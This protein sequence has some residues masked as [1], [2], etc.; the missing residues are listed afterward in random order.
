ML[1]CTSV[2]LAQNPLEIVRRSVER[3][4]A[5][6]ERAKEYTYVVHSRMRERDAGGRVKKEDSEA[7]EVVILYGE[8]F[9]RKIEKDGKPLSPE[10]QHKE[11]QKFDKEMTKR[12]NES[13]EQRRKR[14]AAFEKKRREQREFAREIPDA[15]HFQLMGEEMIGG[16][17]TWVIEATPRA[18]YRPRNSR[19]AML[20]KFKGRMWIDQQEYQWVRMDG[21]VIETVSWGLF[22]ARL[23]KG[24]RIFFEQVRVNDEVWMPKQLKVDLDARIAL[25]KR[26]QGDIDIRFQDFRKFQSESRIVST[27]ELTTT[28]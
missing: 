14:I 9:E 21:E 27:A 26:F 19:A 24:S 28:P 18:E 11:Q 6:W 17:K 12:Q 5:N 10:E 1:A 25:V 13:P 2:I 15:Y 20:K 3:D 8:P 22:L 16:R 23:A 7:E 4:Q